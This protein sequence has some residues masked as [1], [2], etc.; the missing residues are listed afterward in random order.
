VLAVPKCLDWVILRKYSSITDTCKGSRE[1]V[2]GES[3]GEREVR[4]GMEMGERSERG[5]ESPTCWQRVEVHVCDAEARL[6]HERGGGVREASGAAKS[7]D[8]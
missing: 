3:G 5:G 7:E 4:R 6:G 1:R 8:P 2:K